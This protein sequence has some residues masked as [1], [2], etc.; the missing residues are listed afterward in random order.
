MWGSQLWL[1]PPFKAA[2]QPFKLRSDPI[3]SPME[4]FIRV[5]SCSFVARNAFPESSA[6]LHFAAPASPDIDVGRSPWT[7]ADA[8]VGLISM[9]YLILHFAAPASQ[10]TF[11]SHHPTEA[12]APLPATPSWRSIAPSIS[13]AAPPCGIRAHW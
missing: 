11:E 9:R 12:S 2:L 8:L 7:A 5:Y 13:A 10:D 4:F 1:Q 3:P 6:P